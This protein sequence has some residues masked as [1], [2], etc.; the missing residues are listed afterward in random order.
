MTVF[1]LFA[2]LMLAGALFFVI[3]PLLQKGAG[4]AG[5]QQRDAVNLEI[6]RDQLRELDADRAAGTIDDATTWSC[7]W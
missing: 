7:A 2:A 1:L 6:L 4:D 5:H 3:P